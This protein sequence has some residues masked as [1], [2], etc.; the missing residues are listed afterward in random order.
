MPAGCCQKER[1]AP[2][3]LSAGLIAGDFLGDPGSGRQEDANAVCVA[4]T[5]RQRQGCALAVVPVRQEGPSLQ[6]QLQNIRM[7][8]RIAAAGLISP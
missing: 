2:S 6:Q 4:A 8:L 3:G 1:C 7:A 5:S